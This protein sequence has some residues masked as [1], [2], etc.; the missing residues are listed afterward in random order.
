MDVRERSRVVRYCTL[1]HQSTLLPVTYIGGD[2]DVLCSMPE[3]F[4]V[5]PAYGGILQPLE[6][7][8]GQPGANPLPKLHTTS[9]LEHYMVMPDAQEGESSARGWFVVGP[10]AAAVYPDEWLN[11]LMKERRVPLKQRPSWFGYFRSLPV[12]GRN[13]LLHIGALLYEWITGEPLDPPAVDDPPAA[14]DTVPTPGDRAAL[15]LSDSREA[16]IFHQNP[17]TE[18]LLFRHVR[19]GNRKGLQETYTAL[20]G[21]SMGI[22]SKRSPLRH[23]KNISISAITLATRAAMEG[24]MF[25]EAAYTLSDLHIQHIEELTE[26]KQVEAALLEAL[27]DFADRVRSSREQRVSRTVAACQN[28]IYDH[29]H[30][31]LSLAVLASAAGISTVHLSRLFRRETGLT[32]TEYIQRLRVEEAKDLL[33]LTRS[34]LSAISS[35]LQFHDQS[36]FIK[37]FRKH[38]GMTPFQYRSRGSDV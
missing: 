14:P 33:T 31:D 13:R 25:P 32:L 8:L 7:W 5:N 21:E 35:S 23:Q 3:P 17:V 34:P 16:G 4:P 29:L 2:K 28:Y 1:L 38:T 24:G 19:N 9:L 11:E 20:T 26:L 36:Y 10:A 15:H 37:I 22:L 12:A 18:K 6:T 27:G 30:E